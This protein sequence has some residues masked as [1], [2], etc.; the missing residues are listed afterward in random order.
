MFGFCYSVG[1]TVPS[2]LYA[3]LYG[4]ESYKDKVS[5]ES[6]ISYFVAAFLSVVYPYI[7][8]FTGSFSP[9]FIYGA[10]ICCV[11]A[12]LFLVMGKSKKS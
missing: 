11:D 5:T 7:F 12:V 8:D 4:K 3:D 6:S 1:T 10:V 9:I 2:L